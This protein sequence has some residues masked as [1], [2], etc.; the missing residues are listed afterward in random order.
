M[1][2]RILLA[3]LF[4]AFLTGHTPA[5]AQQAGDS[6]GCMEAVAELD[7]FLLSLPNTCSADEDCGGFFLRADTCAPAVML[8]MKL[9]R[10]QE[11][12]RQLV[13]HQMGAQTACA[14]DF[15]THQQCKPKP[16][17]PACHESVCV[18]LWAD[19]Q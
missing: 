9:I 1:V 16:Y 2:K 10:D 8:P 3:A 18:N 19:K 6:E 7:D 4:M 17:R 15:A 12:L 11:V 14:K 5:Y 13:Q